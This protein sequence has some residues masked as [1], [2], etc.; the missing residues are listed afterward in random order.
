MNDEDLIQQLAQIQQH[1]PT[2]PP[3]LAQRIIANVPI[4]LSAIDRFVL[5]L[6][7]N[8]WRS[9][10]A[11]AAPLAVGFTLGLIVDAAPMDEAASWYGAED[12]VYSASF[13]EV[14]EDYDYDDI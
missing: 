6:T 11:A 13:N 14:F 12:L 2:A 3:Y 5:W 4:E 9:A 10:A 8:L 1:E 7:G